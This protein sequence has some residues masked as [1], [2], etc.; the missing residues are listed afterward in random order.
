MLYNSPADVV[1]LW[2]ERYDT[3]SNVKLA[4]FLSQFQAS[5]VSSHTEELW[6]NETVCLWMTIY[7]YIY[8]YRKLRI[9]IV[10]TAKNMSQG[11]IDKELGISSSNISEMLSR[12]Q[13]IGSVLEHPQKPLHKT[14]RKLIWTVNAK[15]KKTARQ[16]M[17]KCDLCY[18]IAEWFF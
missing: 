7:L 10:K 9:K 15:S 8:I 2:A 4:G 16:V 1:R 14:V 12:F 5:Y 11:E 18:I 3:K 17:D 13:D 6:Y